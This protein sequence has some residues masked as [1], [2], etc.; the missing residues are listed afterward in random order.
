MDRKYMKPKFRSGMAIGLDE[1]RTNMTEARD[2]MAEL[3][4][5]PGYI[6]FI[7]AEDPKMRVYVFKDRQSKEKLLRFAKK[8][9]FR[10][11]GSV[12]DAVH[13]RNED[14]QRPH[15]RYI[16]KDVYYKELYK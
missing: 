4:I 1:L 10:T 6:G 16:S 5:E 11:A 14:L 7:D 8:L 9:K 3:L 15:M 2:L 12:L 13:V